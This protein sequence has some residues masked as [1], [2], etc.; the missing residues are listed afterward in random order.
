VA[1]SCKEKAIIAKIVVRKYNCTILY[2]L[3]Q[4][5]YR[6]VQINLKM[7]DKKNKDYII[8]FESKA[9]KMIYEYLKVAPLT[10]DELCMKLNIS[11]PEI[12]AHITEMELDKIVFRDSGNKYYIR[13][14]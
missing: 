4:E 3:Y 2:F 1:I 9:K 10:C 8:T 14:L 12:L 7:I 13:S 11:A 5:N 6:V